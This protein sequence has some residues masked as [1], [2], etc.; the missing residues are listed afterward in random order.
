MT[1]KQRR[2]QLIDSAISLFGQHGF[3]GTTTKALARAAG[4]SEATIFRYFPTKA[5]LY[6][7]VFQDRLSV[8]N[9]ELVSLLEDLVERG[10]DEKVLRTLTRA[11]IGWYSDDRDLHRMLM[12]V[13]LEQTPAENNLL[14]SAIRRSAVFTF[15]DR[16][17]ARRQAEGIFAPGDTDLLAR[18]LTSATNWYGVTT[19]LYGWTTTDGEDERVVEKY[20]R[21]LLAGLKD[22]RSAARTEA[23]H[24]AAFGAPLPRS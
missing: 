16:Y 17:V 14:R 23:G 6:A 22:G 5:D 2:E 7:S 9:A 20:S 15:M 8:G 11:I 1:G 24:R 10:E 12:Y 21:F 19:K 3:K 4:V 13:N 18:L